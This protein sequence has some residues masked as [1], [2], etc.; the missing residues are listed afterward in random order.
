MEG[1]AAP[2]HL[3]LADKFHAPSDQLDEIGPPE[4]FVEKALAVA[5]GVSLRAFRRDCWAEFGDSCESHGGA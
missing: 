3:A 5:H 2:H 4:D 1:A